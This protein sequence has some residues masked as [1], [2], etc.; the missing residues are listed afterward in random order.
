MK[1]DAILSILEAAAE[2]MSIEIKYDDLRKGVVNTE[3]GIF[4]LKD[5]TRILIHKGLSTEEKVDK[6]IALFATLDTEGV[7]LPPAIRKRLESSH[8]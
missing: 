4:T 3:G 6:L 1:D 2:S 7:H 5:E 8:T